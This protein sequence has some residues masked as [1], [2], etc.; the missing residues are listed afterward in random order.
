MLKSLSVIG[1]AVLGSLAVVPI[2]F[3][4]KNQSSC[5]FSCL[6][7]VES[8]AVS[9]EEFAC[10]W[11]D[12]QYHSCLVCDCAIVHFPSSCLRFLIFL[13]V[14]RWSWSA[15]LHAFHAFGP[16]RG[17]HGHLWVICLGFSAVLEFYWQQCGCSASLFLLWHHAVARR[18]YR[19]SCILYRAWRSMFQWTND[20]SVWGLGVRL[21]YCY[22]LYTVYCVLRIAVLWWCYGVTK[23]RNE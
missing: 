17:C 4:L 13:L 19:A 16:G 9:L 8:L 5:F 12:V 2:A 18:G 20:V 10:G 15:S 22:I 1:I 3:G 7:Y 6:V 14:L 11:F 23:K 21:L